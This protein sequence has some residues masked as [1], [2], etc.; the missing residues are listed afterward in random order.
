MN[1]RETALMEKLLA[2]LREARAFIEPHVSWEH[3]KLRTKAM[4]AIHDAIGPSK[5]EFRGCYDKH[6]GHEMNSV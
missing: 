2:A 6:P 4:Q 1:K 3:E 5:P